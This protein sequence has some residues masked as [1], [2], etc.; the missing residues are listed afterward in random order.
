MRDAGA[1]PTISAAECT[2]TTVRQL[3]RRSI[4]D[5]V[6][7]HQQHL[8]GRVLDFGCGER[9]YR[10]LVLGEY[11]PYDLEL[12]YPVGQFDAVLCTQVAQYVHDLRAFIVQLRQLVRPDGHLILTYP[13]NWE[14]VEQADYWRV[15]RE[16][17]QQLLTPFTVIEHVRRAGIVIGDFQL[18]L[19]YGVL[20]RATDVARVPAGI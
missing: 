8:R 3:E 5:F 9:P 14:E 16:G 18:A 6:A 12:P 11:V 20:A 15:T 13:T 4:R 10:D 2:R 19:G 1:Y 7:R 17:M